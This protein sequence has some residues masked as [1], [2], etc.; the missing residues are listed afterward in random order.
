M[1]VFAAAASLLVGN[2]VL[3]RISQHVI[4]G[5]LCGGKFE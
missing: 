2:H 3:A 4:A 5:F 1:V